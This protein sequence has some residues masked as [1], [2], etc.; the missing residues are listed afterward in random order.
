MK[1]EIITIGDEL[2]IGQVIDTNSAWMAEEL[3]MMGIKVHQI[4]S[5]SD[6]R[7][8]ILTSLR[9]ASQRADIIL[10]T[11]GLGPTS[12][13]VTRDLVARLLGKELREDAVVLAHIRHFFESRQRPMPERGCPGR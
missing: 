6:D 12:D 5:I 1:A 3:N 8:H 10:I 7:E 11:G 13:D 2:L 4:T 9:D